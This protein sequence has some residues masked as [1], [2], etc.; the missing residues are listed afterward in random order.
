M[1]QVVWD[2]NRPQGRNRDGVSQGRRYKALIGSMLL[3][4][5]VGTW[6][7]TGGPRS[8]NDIKQANE[9]CL[10]EGWQKVGGNPMHWEVFSL[11]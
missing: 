1:G 6:V 7:L 3:R 10:M 11:E 9:A 4:P 8:F 5:H 2:M